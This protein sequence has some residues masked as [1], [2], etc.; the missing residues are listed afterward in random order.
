MTTQKRAC[1]PPS[2]TTTCRRCETSSLCA[3]LL[4]L[5]LNY[6]DPDFGSALQVAVLCDNMTAA[7]ILL[8]T[9]ANPWASNG[10]TEP[11]TSVIQTGN[12]DMFTRTC[13]KTVLGDSSTVLF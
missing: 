10:F 6:C 5:E 13:E 7:G 9:G 8:D 11:Q 4:P 12:R 1:T 2:A 3:A